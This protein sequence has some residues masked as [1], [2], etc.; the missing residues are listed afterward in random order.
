VKNVEVNYYKIDVYIPSYRGDTRAVFIAGP[1]MGNRVV[2]AGVLF[3][4]LIS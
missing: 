4:N 3:P 1:V 2:L